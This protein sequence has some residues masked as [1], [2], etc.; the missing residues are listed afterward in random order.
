MAEQEGTEDLLARIESNER[1]ARGKARDAEDFA[2][3]ARSLRARGAP[4]EQ[5]ERAEWLANDFRGLSRSAQR[6]AD[7]LRAEL[8]QRNTSDE[9][10]ARS[11]AK[12]E[13]RSGRNLP[14]SKPDGSAVTQSTSGLKV[15]KGNAS[16][17][18]GE[19]EPGAS[20][21]VVSGNGQ[22]KE[23]EPTRSDPNTT[24]TKLTANLPRLQRNQLEDFASYAPLWTMA[25]LTPEQFNNPELYRNNNNFAGAEFDNEISGESNSSTVVFSSAGRFDADRTGIFGEVA[26]EYFVDNFQMKVLTSANTQSGNQNAVSF[27][28]EIL[29]PYSMGLLLQSMQNAAIKAGY[30]NYLDNAPYLLKLDFQ[31]FSESGEAFESVSSKYFV[32][33]LTNVDFNV[34]ESGSRYNVKGIPYNH[35]GFGDT[36]NTLFTDINLE[37]S[38]EG[39]VKEVLVDPKNP[40]S[41]CSVLNRNEKRLVEAGRIS[42]PDVYEVQFPEQSN[43][44]I[45]AES[46]NERSA[47]QSVRRQPQRTI[48]S[49]NAPVITDFGKNEIGQSDFGF[50][51]SDGGNFAFRREDEVTDEEGRLI[52]D[53][54]VIDPKNRTFQFTQKQT[55]TDIITKVV[56]SSKYA[57]DAINPDNTVDGFIR[58]FRLDVQI[59]FLDYDPLIADYARKITYRV[60][61]F[62]VHQ[63]VFSNPSTPG[64]GYEKLQEKIVKGYNYIY[65]GQNTDILKFDVQINNLFYVGNNPSP[66]AD[67]TSEANPN[68]QGIAEDPP[69]ETETPRGGDDRAQAASLGTGRLRP[70]PIDLSIKGGTGTTSTEK[71]VADAFHQ[72]F[73]E[74]SSQDLIKVN[75]EILGDPYYLSTS[76]LANYFSAT[77]ITEQILQDGSMNYEGQDV[78][79]YITF[80]TP[81]DVDT[82]TGLYKFPTQ[83]QESPF[84]GIYKVVIVENTFEEG[85][86]KQN[87]TCLRMPGQSVDFD[88]QPLD[89]DQDNQLATQTT[90]QRKPQEN[91]ADLENR[92]NNNSSSYSTF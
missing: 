24:S 68:Q 69:V 81:A 63:S 86:F 9:S 47:T 85:I 27:S 92:N 16:V 54:M 74:G 1:N 64:I 52:R 30:A 44:F 71:Q 10:E 61:P 31:G 78:F 38:T 17:S 57:A 6:Q 84:S 21:N 62:L 75:L 3:T 19:S 65:T 49:T 23:T 8:A 22:Q 58:W 80:R 43:D 51:Q 60:V 7:R 73:I 56:L 79:I 36:I 87:L 25:C 12:A 76:G 26:P 32:M 18:T 13:A 33:R 48:S 45:R 59:E 82:N 70:K 35:A 40:R 34:D 91:P 15:N 29:E 46:P 83:G 50:D 89:I 37:A 88:N 42:V 55:L 39:T 28:F 77:G 41:L 4:S 66:E 67:T 11:R 5:I 53:K 2:Q 90:V 72:A 14:A 20:A